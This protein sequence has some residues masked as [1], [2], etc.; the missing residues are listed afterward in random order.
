MATQ[1]YICYQGFE[2]IRKVVIS[3]CDGLID[4]TGYQFLFLIKTAAGGTTLASITLGT[5]ISVDLATSTITMAILAGATAAIPVAGLP[6][7]SVTEVKTECCDT[8]YDTQIGP[9]AV[10]E[11][12]LTDGSGN[13]LPPYFI[14]SFCLVP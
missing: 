5:G 14:G 7:V 3:N 8:V 4:L 13:I 1:N 9:T 11:L 2:W 10:C 12:I 6:V